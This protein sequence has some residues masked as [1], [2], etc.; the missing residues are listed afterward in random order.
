MRYRAERPHDDL[1]PEEREWFVL[2]SGLAEEAAP[3]GLADAVLARWRVESPASW[4]AF[5]WVRT[6]VAAALGLG[7]AGVYAAWVLRGVGASGLR[8]VDWA[9]GLTQALAGLLGQL[10]RVTAAWSAM[11]GVGEAIARVAMQPEFV[12]LLAAALVV[13]SVFFRLLHRLL[14]LQRSSS[15]A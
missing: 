1:A 10:A 4:L 7:G 12:A 3:G 6:L 8:G 9:H 14:A 13:A 15:H 2:F 5:G 11:A